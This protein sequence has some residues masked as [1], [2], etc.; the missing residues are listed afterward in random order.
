MA[1]SCS[2]I[3][4]NKKGEEL[5]GFQKYKNELGYKVGSEIFTQ[6]LSPTFQEDYKKTLEFL[7]IWCNNIRRRLSSLGPQINLLDYEFKS[8]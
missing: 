5:K 7:D 1:S 6:V 2:Y 8:S 4:H 3:P